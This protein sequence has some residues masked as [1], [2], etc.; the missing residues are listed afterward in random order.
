MH[1]KLFLKQNFLK[2]F[3]K[4]FLVFFLLYFY[5]FLFIFLYDTLYGTKDFFVVF[6]TTIEPSLH[7][8][9]QYSN[10]TLSNGRNNYNKLDDQKMTEKNGTIY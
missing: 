4:K 1:I 8:F 6:E 2:K 10:S 7:G 3:Q 5:L 9:L